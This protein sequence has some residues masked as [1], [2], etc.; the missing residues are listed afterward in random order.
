[1]PQEEH[2]FTLHTRSF[3]GFLWAQAANVEGDKNRMMHEGVGMELGLASRYGIGMGCKCQDI[4]KARG[5]PSASGEMMAVSYL[6]TCAQVY[7]LT[8][9]EYS[10]SCISELTGYPS[11]LFLFWLDSIFPFSSQAYTI[12][13]STT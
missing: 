7:G 4:Q 12:T 10:T 8:G 9:H 13:R 3:H 1:M 5:W 6:N 2:F 11:I